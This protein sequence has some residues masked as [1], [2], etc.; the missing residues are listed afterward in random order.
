MSGGTEKNI[1]WSLEVP[2]A[3]WSQPIVWGDKVFVT[4]A[5]TENQQ[6]PRVGALGVVAAA[7]EVA[8]VVLAAPV[9]F[10]PPGG[11]P[12]GGGRPG[13]GFGGGGFGGGGRGAAPPNALYTWKVLCLDR[14]T[15]KTLWGKGCQGSQ[16]DA[17][18]S[19]D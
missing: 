12:P 10:G 14:K 9:D 19:L 2:G 15:G 3:A 7:A 6:K 13:G 11:G 8:L 17:R 18:N 16:A 5:I 1:A 4:T